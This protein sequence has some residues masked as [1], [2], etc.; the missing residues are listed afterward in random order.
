MQAIVRHNWLVVLLLLLLLH[1]SHVHITNNL[2]PRSLD[3]STHL[4][5]NGT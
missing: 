5:L 3:E 2:L 4:L 1:K